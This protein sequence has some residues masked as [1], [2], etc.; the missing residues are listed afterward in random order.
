MKQQIWKDDA[1]CLD[2]DTNLFFDTYEEQETLRSAVD[3]ICK[4]CPVLKTCFAVGI[5]NK[6]WGVWGG[7]FL[8]NG[9]ISREFNRHKSKQDWG[10]TWKSLTTDQQ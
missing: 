5:T 6:E 4:E 1:K 8:E 10:N 3:S 9:K 7:I 2:M